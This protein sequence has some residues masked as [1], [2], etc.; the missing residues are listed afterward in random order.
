MS[1]RPDKSTTRRARMTKTATTV[2]LVCHSGKR[3]ASGIGFDLACTTG[4][5]Y[6]LQE[7]SRM[8]WFNIPPFGKGRRGRDFKMDRN[9]H[10]TFL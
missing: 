2:F 7:I 5:S 6:R 3:S 10:N 4:L 9:C 8:Q 1:R